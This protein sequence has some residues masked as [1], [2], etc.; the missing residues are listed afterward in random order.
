MELAGLTSRS[1]AVAEAGCHRL[2]G[3]ST[4]VIAVPAAVPKPRTAQGQSRCHERRGR[5]NPQRGARGLGGEKRMSSLKTLI[6]SGRTRQVQGDNLVPI[7]FEIT[8][9]LP[10]KYVRTDEIP[11]RESGPSSRG[12]N[13]D[14]LIQVRRRAGGGRGR[15]GPA[16]CA[17]PAHR[18]GGESRAAVR[19]AGVAWWAAAKPAVPAEAGLR[20]ADARMFATSFSSYPLTFGYRGASGSAGRQSRRS[21]RQRRRQFLGE[22]LHRQQDAS[23][24][25]AELD[26][27]A[28][29]RAGAGGTEAAGRIC[30]RDR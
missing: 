18:P 3:R 21:R 26:D 19:Q 6:A 2:S 12:F 24:P 15:G 7:E 30:R 1:R 9:E 11:A 13:G 14:G 25:D 22:A 5:R 17:E 4:G 28:E 16:T 27:A 29:S 23:A 20:A 8:I 10:D